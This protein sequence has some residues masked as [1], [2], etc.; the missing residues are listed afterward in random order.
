[1]NEVQKYVLNRAM[2]KVASKEGIV[3]WFKNHKEEAIGAGIGAAGAAVASTL[4][5]RKQNIASRLALI[6]ASTVGGGTAGYA[7][8]YGV[9]ELIAHLKNKKAKQTTDQKQTPNPEQT[10]V[11]ITAA[12]DPGNDTVNY[13][14]G[15]VM[16]SF[17]TWGGEEEPSDKQN[18]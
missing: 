7:G 2:Q 6:I 5:T 15:Q 14:G 3:N 10:Q 16:E 8:G 11:P 1:M 18:K 17:G 9:K 13:H 12:A 4:M